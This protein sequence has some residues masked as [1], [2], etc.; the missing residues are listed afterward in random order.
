MEKYLDNIFFGRFRKKKKNLQRAKQRTRIEEYF[1]SAN[2]CTDNASNISL[3]CEYYEYDG[4]CNTRS[5]R[6]KINAF[7]VELIVDIMQHIMQYAKYHREEI[8][9]SFS[10]S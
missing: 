4:P 8:E 1:I 10:Q 9:T 2:L 6:R 3:Y 5:I 7:E